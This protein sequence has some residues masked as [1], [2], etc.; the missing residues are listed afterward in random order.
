[1]HIF[2]PVPAKST[3]GK[4]ELVPSS[5]NPTKYLHIHSQRGYPSPDRKENGHIT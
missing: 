5:S 3:K 2:G 4:S 1:M